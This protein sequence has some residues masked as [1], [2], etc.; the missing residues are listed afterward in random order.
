V[1][2]TYCTFMGQFNSMFHLILFLLLRFEDHCLIMSYLPMILYIQLYIMKIFVVVAL[3]E[4]WQRE[5]TFWEIFLP[6]MR[7]FFQNSPENHVVFQLANLSFLLTLIIEHYQ[8][9]LELFM[10]LHDGS[11]PCMSLWSWSHVLITQLCV[12]TFTTVYKRWSH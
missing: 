5:E 10:T 11:L 7:I 8:E 2:K 1:Q 9:R 3:S 6:W 4:G 12:H